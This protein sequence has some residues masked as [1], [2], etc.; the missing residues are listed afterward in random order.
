MNSIPKRILISSGAVIFLLFVLNL[1]LWP[2][3]A[4]QKSPTSFGI[5]RDGYQ[6]AFDLLTEMHFPVLRSYRRPKLLP[7]NQTVWFVSPSFL[8]ED[9]P[10]AHDQA[11]EAVEWASRGG[12]A[13]IF[14]DPASDWK[15]L[16]LTR[17]VE[18]AEKSAED[19]TFIKGDIAPT[20]RW[21]DIA[22]LLH[23]TEAE[24][25]SP[26]PKAGGNSHERVR[27][28]A[29][30]KP[31]ALEVA[32][33]KHGGR[34]IAIADDN[35]LRNEHLADADASL[36]LV[37]L[38]RA[39]GPPAFDE[40]SHGLAPPAS[41]T[42]AILDSRAI[43]PI[44]IGLILALLWMLSQRSWPRRS[45]EGD[46]EMPAPS[47]ASFVESLSILYSRAADPAAVFR[48]YRAGFLRRLRRQLGVRPDFPE[49][50]LLERIARDRSLSEA[51]RHWLLASDAPPDQHHLVIA[52]RAIESYGNRTA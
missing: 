3:Q 33:G 4:L 42:L 38:V 5:N 37:D 17:E 7:I 22:D 36:V 27:M 34:I 50:L 44:V 40:H 18:K 6:A 20:P 39:F 10:S 24:S 11:H 8:D 51:T 25:K 26:D 41:L 19:R 49:D 35:F 45:L 15:V 29:D 43:M 47:I 16:G 14:G 21:L 52:V 31:F 9:K 2:N 28:T 12:T 32:V 30:G 13:V 1:W 48:A 46:L 23:F